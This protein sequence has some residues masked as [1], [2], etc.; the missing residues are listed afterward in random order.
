MFTKA[1]IVSLVVA[2]TTAVVQ[3]AEVQWYNTKSCGGSSSV[4]NRDVGCNVCVDPVGGVFHL[5]LLLYVI[6]RC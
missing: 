3:A 4:D 6:R 2:L 5:P 1:S